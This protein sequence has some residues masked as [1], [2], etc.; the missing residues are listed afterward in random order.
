MGPNHSCLFFFLFSTLGRPHSCWSC[1]SFCSQK[2]FKWPFG[3]S[4]ASQGAII[5][6]IPIRKHT[7]EKLFWPSNLADAWGLR[8]NP[9]LKRVRR[10][11]P[12]TCGL[13]SA[14][15]SMSSAHVLDPSA[16]LEKCME[17]SPTMSPL[18]YFPPSSCILNKWVPA[19]EKDEARY[20]PHLC[21]YDS[22]AVVF[23]H[24]LS[25]VINRRGTCRFLH[26]TINYT[27]SS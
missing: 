13:C 8:V 18:F 27:S 7:V 23:I 22:S 4:Q 24:L 11:L 9:E 2:I 25:Y 10:L 1:F 14:P 16:I 3:L 20:E 15:P 19:K 5:V 21:P 17:L 6:I 26:R 12:S